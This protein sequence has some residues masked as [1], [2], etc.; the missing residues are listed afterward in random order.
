MQ[1][2]SLW[3]IIFVFAIGKVQSRILRLNS[4]DRFL[5]AGNHSTYE[6]CEH[7]Y[8]F[9][10]CADS[11]AGY[12]FLIAVYQY[13]LVV[14]EKLVSNGSKTLFNILG[15]GIFGATLFQILK[16]FPRSILVIASGVFSSKEKAQNQVYTG[17]SANVGATVLNLTLMWGICVIF[18]AKEEHATLQQP[19]ESSLSNRLQV[20][21][22][23]GVTIDKETNYT[24]GIMLLSLI[25]FALVELVNA[26]NTYLRRRIV[27]YTALVVSGIFLLSYFTYQLWDPWIQKRSLEYSKYENLLAAFL[28]HVQRHA[29]G[30]LVDEQGRPDIQVIERLFFE[31]DKDANKSITLVELENLVIDM[32]SGKVKVDKNYAISKILAVFDRNNDQKIDLEEFVEG[33]KI[34]IEEA[35]MLAKSDDSTTRRILNKASKNLHLS[36]VIVYLFFTLSENISICQQVVQPFIKKQRDEIAEIEKLMAKILKHVES[37]ALEAEHFLKDD[38]TPNIE[39][40]KEIFHQYDTDGNN[41]ITRKEL[42]KLIRSVKYGEV[43]LNS[44]DSVTKVMKD[45]DTDRN[46]MIDEP[47]FV[48]GMTRWINEAIRVTNCKDKKRAIDEYDKIM[49]GEVEKLVYEVEKDGKINYKL[50]TWAFNK[51][52]F[53]VILGIA[54]LTFCAKPLVKSIENLSEA[55]GMP[56]FLIPFVI[57]PLALNARMALAAIF[58]AS[59]KSS[60][61]S[62]LTFSEIYGDVVMNNIMGMATLLAIVC[63]K[64]LTWDYSAQVII[65]LVAC[66]IIGLLALFSPRY[67]LWTTL[68]AFS[69]YPSCIM[70]FYFLQKTI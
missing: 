2:L 26:F 60:K 8:G 25:P 51:S 24:A 50:L 70:I 37:Q 67:P 40:I 61:T 5:S 10:P 47:E 19:A 13:L 16:A 65:V 48:D 46:D 1:S 53:E 30:K 54:M 44:D 15:T 36:L 18:G 42:E 4:P 9:F 55:I 14:G 68:L 28:Q 62:S 58:P 63:A 43:Q 17:V 39:R 3:L 7:I 29:K 49:W 59:Q 6:K 33:Y 66:A 45:F 57:V 11:V 22:N 38:G 64:D 52:I 27:I 12:I 31:T 35:K 21:K 56:S 23:N 32:Q 34:W 41:S 20:L 69:L